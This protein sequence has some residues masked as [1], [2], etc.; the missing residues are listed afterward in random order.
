MR[1]LLD[2]HILIWSLSAPSR[3]S[4][5]AQPLIKDPQSDLAFSAVAIWEIAIKQG[6]N[7]ADF[8]VEPRV[9]QRELLE[10]GYQEIPITGA[11][12]AGVQH[13][14]SCTA[15]QSTAS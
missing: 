14:P 12:G 1:L 10:R 7:R 11:H 13:L 9:L 8:D 4:R 3:L 6:L 2:T 15:I 5:Y